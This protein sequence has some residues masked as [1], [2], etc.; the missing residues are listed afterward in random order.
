VS[1]LESPIQTNE[2]PIL[3]LENIFK[4]YH[5]DKNKVHP[6]LMVINDLNVNIKT[7]EFVIVGPSGCGKSTLLNLVSGLE[8]V[9]DGEMKV[10]DKSLTH[11]KIQT[12]S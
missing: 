2:K 4:E 5:D 12:E 10:D 11:R 1:N 8:Q 6:K 9:F 3:Q 7:G